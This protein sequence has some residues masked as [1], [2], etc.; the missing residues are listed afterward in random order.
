MILDEVQTGME[1]T[2]NGHISHF[3]TPDILTLAKAL[4]GGTAIGAMIAKP[5]IAAALTPGTHASTFGGNPLACAAGIATIQ[6]IEEERLLENARTMGQYIQQKLAELKKNHSIIDSVRGIGLM[7]GL[8]LNGPGASIVSKCLDKGL[9]LTAPE[10]VLR[11][12]PSMTI[13][14]D[15][16]DRPFLFLTRS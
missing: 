14:A 7:I 2:G 3:D 9:R 1:R 8:Q 4:G 5:E 10:T 12:M 16:I 11:V 13:T 15:L 6:A